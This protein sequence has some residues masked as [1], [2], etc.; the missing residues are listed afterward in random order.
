[1]SSYHEPVMGKEVLDLMCTAE[2]GLYLDGTVGGGGH[3]RM[4]LDSSEKC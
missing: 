2:D 3:T 4:I 1:M